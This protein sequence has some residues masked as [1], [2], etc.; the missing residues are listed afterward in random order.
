MVDKYW[1]CLFVLQLVVETLDANPG[2]KKEYWVNART[3]SEGKYTSPLTTD[4][5]DAG[6]LK[7]L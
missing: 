7:T 5:F 1:K 6:I 2:D 3:D 4:N